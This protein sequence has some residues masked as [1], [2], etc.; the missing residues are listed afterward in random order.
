MIALPLRTLA[1]LAAWCLL[2]HGG[3]AAGPPDFLREV[4]PILSSYC[5]KCHGPDDAARKGGLRLDLREAA[6]GSGKSGDRAIVPGQPEK[7]AVVTRITSTDEDEQMPPPSIKHPLQAEQKEV[8]RRWIAAGAEYRPHWAFVPPRAVSPPALRLSGFVVRNPI[9]AF[10]AA[11][12]QQEKLKP[13]READRV[14]L[15]RR[16]SLDLLGLPPTPEEADAF[17]ADQ[18][19]AAYER[20]VDRLLASPRY[21]ERWARK[22]LDLARY[23]DSNG[24]EKDR[25][26]SI[27]PYRD[28]VIRALN[29]DMPFDRFTLEQLA[30]DMLPAPTSDQRIATGFHRNT[31]L[32]E[33]G[34]IDPL[35]FRFHAMVDRVS[36]TGTAWLGLTIGCA[37]CHTHKYDPIQHREYYQFMAFL[38]NADEPELDLPPAD[39]AEKARERAQRAA[40]RLAA[41]PSRW[42]IETGPMQWE[43]VIPTIANLSTNDEARV[44]EDGS[45]L[46]VAPGPDKADVTLTFDTALTNITHLRLEA[47][48]HESLPQRGPGRTPH[49][50]FVLS[51]IGVSQAGGPGADGKAAPA[52]PLAIRSATATAEQ[53]GFAVA[54]AFDG[55]TTTGWAV[56]QAGRILNTNH[57]AIFAFASPAGLGAGTRLTVRLRQRHGGSHTMGRVALSVGV[58]LADGRSDMVRREGEVERAFAAWMEKERNRTVTWRALRPGDMRSN[59][60]LLTRLADDSVLASGDI[61]KSDTYELTFTNLPGPITGMR[62]EALPDDSLPAHGPGLTYYEGPKGDFFLG[63]F[64]VEADGRPVRF[65]RASES[66]AKNNFGSVAS[67]RAATDGDPQ[68]GWTCADRPGEAHN[69]VFIPS[70]PIVAGQLHVRMMFG[71]HYAC[72]LGRFRIS[73]TTD[74]RGGEARELPDDLATLLAGTP[75]GSKLSEAERARLREQFLLTAPPLAAAAREIRELRKPPGYPTTLVLR[76][77]PANAT[78]PT[79]IHTRGE[80]LQPTTEVPPGVPQFLPGLSADAPRNRVT[81]A[82]WLVARDNPLTARVVVNRHWAAFFGQGLVGTQN[83][84]GFQGDLP[85]HPELLDWLAVR[86]MEDGWSFKKLHRLI[87]TSSTYRQASRISPELL[88]RDP[89]NRLLAR[90]PRGRLDAEILRDAALFASGLLAE[91]MYG[92]PV[93]PAQPAGVTE[94][95]YGSPRWE[96]S[97]GEDQYRRSL[98]TFQKRSAPF[99]MFNTFDAPS[100]ETCV[101]RREV[102]NTP[103]QSLTLLNDVALVDAA[104]HL[105]GRAA[106]QPGDDAQKARFLFRRVLTR[107]PTPAEQERLLDFVQ[108]QRARL[109]EGQLNAADL[110]G[111]APTTE[112]EA[113]ERATWMTVARAV[114]NLDEAITKQ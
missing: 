81:L 49:G 72:S 53:E 59:Q 58:P 45:V 19:P 24:Y 96:V 102:S 15:I 61:S 108:A 13:S 5:F 56:H 66:Y 97:A 94:V 9:D 20:L 26:R 100:G 85:T 77:R 31:M 105:G 111:G 1:V 12:W 79:F 74:P 18:D 110:A 101:A 113:Q 30:G 86:F 42:P 93:K 62:L 32:N 16:L 65:A 41:L 50:N 29:A 14:T 28:W 89:Q 4:R 75:D 63:E 84:F 103:L 51:E 68:T 67:A 3:R 34:G 46:F 17:V 71:R 98:Y 36:T 91:K 83:D 2:A 40:Q 90:G 25:D 48:T 60:P 8:L 112:A 64:Q 82:R 39:A 104:R 54:G 27:W 95:A 80:F 73:I 47:L 70:E 22:W 43:K 37:Q 44:L 11:R 23:A 33:E 10:V 99:A 57:A 69:A 76:E 6:L 114:L 87:A 35:E 78:R 52:G 106:Q 109:R 55:S 88:A 107:P 21:G 7:S 38:N 92:P